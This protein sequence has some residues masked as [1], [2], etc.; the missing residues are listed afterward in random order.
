MWPRV[1][2][3]RVCACVLVCVCLSVCA[4]T[5]HPRASPAMATRPR[6]SAGAVRGVGAAGVGA[7]VPGSPVASCSAAQALRLVKDARCQEL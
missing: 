4:R 6:G 1:C 7:P 2:T 5:S 3:A